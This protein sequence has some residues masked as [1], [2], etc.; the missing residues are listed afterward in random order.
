MRDT[1]AC[2]EFSELLIYTAG[3]TPR[4]VNVLFFDK[5]SSTHTHNRASK[6]AIVKTKVFVLP[7]DAVLKLCLL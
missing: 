2:A 7:S 6:L 5:T 3:F 4:K 1:G